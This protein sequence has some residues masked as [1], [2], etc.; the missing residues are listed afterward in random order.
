MNA[1]PTSQPEETP[2]SEL[3]ALPAHISFR[4]GTDQ[5][6]DAVIEFLGPFVDSQ[7]LLPRTLEEYKVLLKHGFLAFSGPEIV[8]FAAVEI[9]SRKLAEIQALAVSPSQQRQGIGHRLVQMCI[10][11]ARRENVVELMAITASEKLFS[12][13]GF[14]YTLPDL[15]RALFV[16]P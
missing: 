1:D 4:D 5:D 2:A 10:E 3:M 14:H 9:Y 12:D 7:H 16:N 15:K 6:L 8:G 13:V 11:R